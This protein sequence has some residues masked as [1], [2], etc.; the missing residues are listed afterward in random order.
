MAST[1]AAAQV[2]VPSCTG[3]R[4]SSSSAKVSSA[5]STAVSVK[6]VAPRASLEAAK[7]VAGNALVATGASLLLA[8][9]AHADTVISMGTADGQLLFDPAAVTVAAG[10]KITFKNVGGFPHNI[11]F[12]EGPGNVDALS[13]DDLFNAAGEE[14]SITL[15]EKGNYEYYCEPHSGVMRGKITVS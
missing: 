7:K 9:G 3:L 10:E 15:T 1:A 14:Y 5:K 12:D 2:A 4:V 11:V 13:H 6:S 8:F